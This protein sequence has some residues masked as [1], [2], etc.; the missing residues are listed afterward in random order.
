MWKSYACKFDRLSKGPSGH[1]F[2]PFWRTEL[3][4]LWALKYGYKS[5]IPSFPFGPF[6]P[7]FLSVFTTWDAA[8]KSISRILPCKN[9][10][11]VWMKLE[12]ARVIIRG[13]LVDNWR[14]GG[15]TTNIFLFPYLLP[16]M[17]D[18]RRSRGGLSPIFCAQ[19]CMKC[20]EL[21]IVLLRRW[22]VVHAVHQS[23]YQICLQIWYQ[24]LAK[25]TVRLEN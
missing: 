16:L 2:G 22:T 9:Y 13:C 23:H 5:F 8:S 4:P 25:L 17:I 1:H 6:S 7:L 10:R 11:N 21:S 14:T 3:F 20:R 24:I 18:C 19:P 12:V 15:V